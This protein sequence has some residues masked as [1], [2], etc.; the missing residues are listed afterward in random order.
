[1]VTVDAPLSIDPTTP[2][3]GIAGDPAVGLPTGVV[4]T[5]DVP[6]CAVDAHFV[7][8]LNSYTGDGQHRLVLA[9]ANGEVLGW[10][11]AYAVSSAGYASFNVDGWAASRAGERAS[12]RLSSYGGGVWW[13]HTEA[14]AAD[15]AP[16]VS[17]TYAGDVGGCN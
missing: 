17:F 12:V 16:F 15:W 14:S 7:V 11:T 5:V 8:W 1:M 6:T 3:V 2:T 10:T 4:L 9:D 13:F